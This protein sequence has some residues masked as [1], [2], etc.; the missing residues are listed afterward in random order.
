MTCPNSGKVASRKHRENAVYAGRW[1]A[2][3]PACEGVAPF[4]A[5]ERRAD[6]VGYVYRYLEH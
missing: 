4:A 5:A 1:L 6:N 2:F 3:C